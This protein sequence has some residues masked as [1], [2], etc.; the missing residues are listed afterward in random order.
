MRRIKTLAPKRILLLCVDSIDV[1]VDLFS[2]A[3][4]CPGARLISGEISVPIR[5]SRPPSSLIVHI[6]PGLVLGA[7]VRCELFTVT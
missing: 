7:I 6:S 2:C 4:A 5:R 1:C 3:G